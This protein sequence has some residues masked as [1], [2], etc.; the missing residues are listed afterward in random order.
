MRKPR[1]TRPSNPARMNNPSTIDIWRM[2]QAILQ[3]KRRKSIPLS[4]AL[5]EF[6]HTLEKKQIALPPQSNLSKPL[7]LKRKKRPKSSMAFRPQ[8]TQTFIP[9]TQISTGYEDFPFLEELLRAC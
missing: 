5:I 1:Q 3:I 8:V 9:K 4:Q 2:F 6:A 7:A